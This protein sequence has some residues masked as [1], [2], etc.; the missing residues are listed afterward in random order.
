M[1]PS[2]VVALALSALSLSGCHL[3]M[4]LGYPSYEINYATY[5]FPAEPQNL[6]PRINSTA[7]DMN[8]APPPTISARFPL[9]FSSNRGEAGF[10]FVPFM[11]SLDFD[12]DSGELGVWGQ[13]PFR[14]EMP[15]R[16]ALSRI[17]SN[18]DELGPLLD[19][20]AGF[21]FAS[22]RGGDLD[23]YA[24]R[25]VPGGW[26]EAPERIEELCSDGN[27]AYPTRAP[28]GGWIL[29]S[30]RSGIGYDL[31]QG[32]ALLSELSSTGDDKCPFVQWNRLV[33]A[34][35]RPGG[36]GGFDLYLS[37][38]V[39]GAWTAPINLGPDVN[40]EQDE[41]RPVLV[42]AP[43]FENDLLIFSSDR[44]GGQGGFDLYFAG[45]PR[46]EIELSEGPLGE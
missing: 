6:G 37:R 43:E 21:V 40:S 44:P 10:D 8:A 13:E 25:R 45:F 35:D 12:Q 14:G 19:P 16:A 30:D 41:Y 36:H 1:K 32:G 22:D 7:D 29:C 18:A 34:S 28:D 3:I 2:H 24:L 46:V 33:F 15:A 31:Y 5:A 27:D 23:V 26:A 20:Q 11:V 38:W 17:N 9:I 4:A 42:S 39:D